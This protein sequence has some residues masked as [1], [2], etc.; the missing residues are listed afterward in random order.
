RERLFA[1]GDAAGFAEPFTGEG[2]GWALQSAAALAPIA[3]HAA[4]GWDPALQARWEQ[5]WRRDVLS[6]QRSCRVIA[7]LLP[8]PRIL[9]A[10]PPG[11]CLPLL[12]RRDARPD[13]RGAA[14]ALAG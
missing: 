12:R 8:S 7:R 5:R 6:R 14:G 4:R 13:L 10:V 2:I 3:A 11:L 1:L 9:A